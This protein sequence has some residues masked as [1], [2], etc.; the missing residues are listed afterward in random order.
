MSILSVSFLLFIL[1]LCLVYF[2]VP[3]RFQWWVLLAFSLGFYAL[4]GLLSL[5]WLLLTA[6]SAWATARYIQDRA[7]AEKAFLAAHKAEL[8]K[9]ERSARKAKGKKTRRRALTLCILLNV[10]VLCVFKYVHFL[11][12]QANALAGL[13]GGEVRDSVRWIVPLGVSFYTFQTLGYLCDVYWG[14]AKAERNPLKLLLFTS[15]FPQ[16]T[17]GPISAWNDLSA[18]LFAPHSLDYDSF[19]LGAQRLIWGFFKK[20]VAANILSGYVS[21]VFA[22]YGSYSGLATFLGALCYAAQ[23]YADFSGYMDIMC[24]LC[25][26]LGIRLTENFE[27]PYFSK[28][29]AE[30]WRRWHMS[31]G[32]W[33]KNYVYYPIAVSKWNQR[34]GKW[35]KKRLGKAFGNYLP[36]TL[37]L[38]V[39]WL[40]TGLWHGASWGYIAWGGVNGLF[41]IFSM[42][43]EGPYAKWKKALRIRESAWL[44][45]AFQ[46][47]RTFLLVTFI[48]VLPE[49]GSLRDGLGLW[50]RIFT[51]HSLPHSLSELLPFVGDR[52]PLLAVLFSVGLMFLVSLLQRKGSVRALLRRRVPYLLRICVFVFLF[53]LILYFGVPASGGLGDF[54]YAQY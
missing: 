37:A 46:V 35:A 20:M 23:I 8:S 33:F 52:R 11:L 6:L 36:A 7:D 53:F 9:E 5:P 44:W 27:R 18:Q 4:G 15:F 22:N 38:V 34:L 13:F 14:K 29:V 32:V 24:G 28:S 1:G 45:R 47:G 42:W 26:I 12:A 54:I 21:D 43:M 25:Q 16:I 50:K 48:K 40:A 49:V 17:Q 51:E 39:T 30:Y 41:I 3:K 31:L 2:L 10:G 19:S